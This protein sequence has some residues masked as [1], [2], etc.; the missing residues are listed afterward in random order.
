MGS[1]AREGESPVS[2]IENTSSRIQSTTRHEK[3]GGKK[4]RPLRKAK[5]YPVTDSE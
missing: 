1:S 2:E 5:Y 3:P 4:R